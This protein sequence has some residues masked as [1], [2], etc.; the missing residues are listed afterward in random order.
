[1]L[2]VASLTSQTT[3]PPHHHPSLQWLRACCRPRRLNIT[4]CHRAFH[5]PICSIRNAN[6]IITLRIAIHCQHTLTHEYLLADADTKI[7]PHLTYKLH[8]DLH[9]NCFRV[10]MLTVLACHN[11]LHKSIF[12]I[13]SSL[14]IYMFTCITRTVHEFTH[15]SLIMVINVYTTPAP[16]RHAI[17]QH[18]RTPVNN[19]V[20]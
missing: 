13:R 18:A 2:C 14:T 6:A 20:K 8:L 11:T 7:N 4:I 1:M 16:H 12:K 17:S 15:I 3:I 5:K 19:Y 9:A 10:P